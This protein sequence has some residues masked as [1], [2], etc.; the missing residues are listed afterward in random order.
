M[1]VEVGEFGFE[2]IRVSGSEMV[3]YLVNKANLVHNF[4]YYVYFFPL[5]VS[6][7]YVSIIR[8]NNCIYATL[9]TCYSVW[10]TVWYAGCTSWIPD[11][12]PY[13]ITNTK[14]RIDSYFS[15][16][17][18]HSRPKHVEKRNKHTKKNYALSWLYLQDYRRK[19]V[20]QNVKTLVMYRYMR[21]VY[22]SVL[23]LVWRLS[24]L[25]EY[26]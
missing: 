9:S 4:S 12:H 13:R 18:A 15:W 25:V 17:W 10:V 26:V 16:W 5:H 21:I 19:H 1:R 20:Q 23:V 8:R 22:L 11:S 14:R 24:D 7:D 6:E 3:T 2:M